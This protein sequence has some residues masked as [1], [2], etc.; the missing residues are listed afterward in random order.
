M[1]VLGGAGA[2]VAPVVYRLESR[3]RDLELEPGLDA[4]MGTGQ[5]FHPSMVSPRWNLVIVAG[6]VWGRESQ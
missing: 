6:G 3:L 5:S 4:A 2:A 1:G